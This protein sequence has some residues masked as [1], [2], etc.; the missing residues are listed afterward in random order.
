MLTVLAAAVT[1]LV[2][3]SPA[4]AEGV[5]PT[6]LHSAAGNE[7][8]VGLADRGS[9]VVGTR[10]VLWDCHYHPDQLWHGVPGLGLVVSVALDSRC[11][12]L[13]GGGS[14]VNGTRLVL[15]TCD[16]GRSDQKWEFYGLGDGTYLLRNSP[17]RRCVGL[18]DR[19]STANGTELVLWDCHRNPDQRWAFPVSPQDFG[20]RAPVVGRI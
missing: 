10:L 6:A 7:K 17:T 12:G 20:F 11:V 8:C 16:N 5:N 4:H 1:A 18:A 14:T 2:V 3:P 13:D 9:T 19:G 15:A